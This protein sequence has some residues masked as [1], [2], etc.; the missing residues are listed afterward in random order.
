M[1]YETRK[2]VE[3]YARRNKI[4]M[5]TV[6]RVAVKMYLNKIKVEVK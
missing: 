3:E 1:A 5:A 2:R 6:V 4:T